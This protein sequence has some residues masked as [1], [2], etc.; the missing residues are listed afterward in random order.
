[1][2]AGTGFVLLFLGLATCC[3]AEPTPTVGFYKLDD[4]RISGATSV[5]SERSSYSDLDVLV[6]VD[7]SGNVIA[8]EPINNFEKLDP[9]PA[10]ALIKSWKFR[11]PTF[12]GKSVNAVGRVSI[13]YEMQP[14]PPN[15]EVQFP[16]STDPIQTVVSL[17]RG[18][19]LGQCPDYHVSVRGDGLVE[20]N[21]GM[22]HF[23]GQPAEIHLQYNGHN[24]LLPGHHTAQIDPAAVANLLEKFRKAQFFGLKPEYV[25]PATDNPTQVLTLKI[26]KNRKVVTDYIGTM[27]GMP[28]DVRDLEAAVDK[29][30]GTERWVNGNADTLIELDAARFDYQS[31]DAALLAA[32]AASKL[33]GYRPSPGTEQLIIGMV[34]RG[35][36]LSTPIEKQTLGA[37]LLQA[38]AQSGSDQLFD[39]LVA[40]GIFNTVTKSALNDAFQAVGCSPA[41]ARALVKAGA[42][43]RSSG[44][45]G[46]ALT[47]LRSGYSTCHATPEKTLEMASE[48]V[49]LGVPLEARD[50]LGWTALMGC[51]SPELAKLLL[52]HGADPNVRAND[53]TTAVL[54]TDDD[55][56]AL[57]LL[58]AGADPN[59][60]NEK[61]S[62][63]T[64]A[65]KWH[66]P[67]TLAWLDA[68]GIR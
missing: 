5:V 9:A 25:L 48:L 57:L 12:E 16:I 31:K 41:I 19:C 40:H 55:R 56:V 66:M 47:A 60:R 28:Q 44:E 6:T 4:L 64:Q 2:N 11:H 3:V 14:T 35:T 23:K 49:T 7:T 38:A 62:V 39:A 34:Q 8:V 10:L 58:R 27:A 24:V 29:I 63:R 50:N 51:D 59:A 37:I 21:T 52:D 26:G 45:S 36:Q 33:N 54:A 20:F 18:A 65:I 30:A 1:M 46:T 43:P 53:G 13:A 17:D 42:D 32:A 68:H 22:V 61:G 67:A 15:P